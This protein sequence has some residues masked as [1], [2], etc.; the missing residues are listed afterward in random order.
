M[1][2]IQQYKRA[3]A[4]GLKLRPIWHIFI[5]LPLYFPYVACKWFSEF[6]EKVLLEM[7]A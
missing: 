1:N 4:Q 2:I 5:L 7:G 3:R 6:Y